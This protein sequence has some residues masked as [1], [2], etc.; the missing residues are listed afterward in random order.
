MDPQDVQAR[1][2]LAALLFKTAMPQL[3]KALAAAGEPP[4][5]PGEKE[6]LFARIEESAWTFPVEVYDGS[7]DAGWEERVLAL[8]P[9]RA[10]LAALVEDV[11][12]ARG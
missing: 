7:E 11:V 3:A 10:R 8:H 4:P 6:R 9:V 12:K 5:R 2:R 1:V